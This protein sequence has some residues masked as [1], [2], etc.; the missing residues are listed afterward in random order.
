MQTAYFHDLHAECLKPGEE[1]VE[2][3]L[4]LKRTVQ[5]GLDRLN[6]RS[7]PLK[8]KESLGREHPSYA[9]LVVAGHHREPPRVSE[10]PWHFSRCSCPAARAPF[11]AGD[12]VT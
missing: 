3:G 10:R 12:F 6:G 7:E 4:I 1:P 2:G 5:N 9:D 8:V 11:R